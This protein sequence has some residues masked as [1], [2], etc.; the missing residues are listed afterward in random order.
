MTKAFVLASAL[1]IGGAAFGLSGELALAAEAKSADAAKADAAKKDRCELDAMLLL[2]LGEQKSKF[3]RQCL[4]SK[5]PPPGKEVAR[6]PSLVHPAGPKMPG[7][8]PLRGANPPRTS[9]GST[10]ISNA[11]IAPSAPVVGSSGI[12]TTGSRATSISGSS[13]T[14]IG[15]SNPG[16]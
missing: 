10:A 8:T 15:S 12:S 16:R 6:R 4:A 13:G 11:P 9:T 2:Y 3:I 7:V 1:L 5:G 14:S